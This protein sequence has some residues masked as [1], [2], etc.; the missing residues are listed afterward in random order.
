MHQHQHETNKQAPITSRAFYVKAK[1][2]LWL[3]T[4]GLCSIMGVELA[5]DSAQALTI[6]G[7]LTS[8]AIWYFEVK[9]GDVHRYVAACSLWHNVQCR[10]CMAK[11]K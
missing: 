6:P 5:V 3:Q 8:L 2:N 9:S 4:F 11:R 10:Y 1:Q 7:K